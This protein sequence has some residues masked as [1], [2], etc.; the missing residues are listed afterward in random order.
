MSRQPHHPVN[1]FNASHPH[2]SIP[3]M[4]C[5]ILFAGLIAH[6]LHRLISRRHAHMI[7]NHVTD[8]M[9]DKLGK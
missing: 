3:T 7:A 9:L 6:L 8:T 2:L 1:H 4:I 5:A